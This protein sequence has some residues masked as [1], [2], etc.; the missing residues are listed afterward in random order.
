MWRYVGN[1]HH[2]P[3]ENMAELFPRL[4]GS[5]CQYLMLNAEK[6]LEL[7]IDIA[8]RIGE[9]C[10]PA[11]QIAYINVLNNERRKYKAGHPRCFS[12]S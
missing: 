2:N 10:L 9:N 4:V 6:L 1:V 3:Y 11:Y 12:N 5:L 8:I 7:N